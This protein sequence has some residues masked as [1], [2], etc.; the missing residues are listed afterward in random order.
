MAIKQLSGKDE[1]AQR[2]LTLVRLK[3]WVAARVVVSWW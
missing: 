2:R 3:L 1:A